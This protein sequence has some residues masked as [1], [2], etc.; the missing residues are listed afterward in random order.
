M[1]QHPLSRAH[2]VQMI[3]LNSYSAFAKYI[4]KKGSIVAKPK[5]SHSEKIGV[6][7]VPFS[8]QS[9]TIEHALRHFRGLGWLNDSDAFQ[10]EVALSAL[11]RLSS[12]KATSSP[13]WEPL[14]DNDRERLLSAVYRALSD[15]IELRGS[16]PL[17]RLSEG[18]LA[19]AEIVENL[20]TG[21]FGSDDHRDAT[22]RVKILIHFCRVC[23][24]EGDI[25]NRR[26]ERERDSAPKLPAPPD[27]LFFG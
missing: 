4:A 21:S 5:A 27:E 2:V 12:E 10:L 8:D 7:T 15:A 11:L 24:H 13:D 18:L 20:R 6:D 22:S 14:D 9:D 25:S 17:D 26:R 16:I 19:A 3:R 23:Q 1:L